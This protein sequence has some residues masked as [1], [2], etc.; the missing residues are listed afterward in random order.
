MLFSGIAASHLL[1][2][3]EVYRLDFEMVDYTGKARGGLSLRMALDS[4]AIVSNSSPNSP[5]HSSPKAD[6]KLGPGFDSLNNGEWNDNPLH[7]VSRAWRSAKGLALEDEDAIDSEEEEEEEH[8]EV[9]EALRGFSVEEWRDNCLSRPNSVSLEQRI[10]AKEGWR[11]NPIARPQFDGGKEGWLQNPLKD[12]AATRY[13]ASPP[14]VHGGP[15][16]LDP[17]LSVYG[18]EWRTNPLEGEEGSSRR[19][20]LL[21]SAK[22]RGAR[23]AK[24]KNQRRLHGIGRTAEPQRSVLGSRWTSNPAAGKTESAANDEPLDVEAAASTGIVHGELGIGL[25]PFEPEA[26]SMTAAASASYVPQPSSGALAAQLSTYN[27]HSPGQKPSPTRG[28]TGR[29]RRHPSTT[30]APAD[31]SAVDFRDMQENKLFRSPHLLTGARPVAVDDSIWEGP[32]TRNSLHRS[33]EEGDTTAGS[34]ATTAGLEEFRNPKVS[35]LPTKPSP[36]RGAAK[37]TQRRAAMDASAPRSAAINPFLLANLTARLHSKA[38]AASAH[39]PPR[40]RGRRDAPPQ[41][42]LPGAQ[43]DDN[44]T[45]SP[46]TADLPE[47]RGNP[48]SPTDSSPANGKLEEAFPRRTFLPTRRNTILDGRILSPLPPS[49]FETGEDKGAGTGQKSPEGTDGT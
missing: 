36:K 34:G 46:E 8:E 7:G 27:A 41:I 22:M 35:P 12:A 17:R 3:G 26:N 2:A 14:G 30:A 24:N 23:W 38:K 5:K 39:T 32:V 48:L 11:R 44:W 43:D 10:G 6:A 13:L 31:L 37:Q 1:P 16:T 4:P 19:T 9:P 42:S 40:R 47:F 29:P 45:Q 33:A 15:A 21:V 25:R 20:S 18:S 28:H 49:P